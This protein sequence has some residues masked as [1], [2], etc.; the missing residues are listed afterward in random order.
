MKKKGYFKG[1]CLF[2]FIKGESYP[3]YSPTNLKLSEDLFGEK[4]DINDE[5]VKFQFFV[6]VILGNT[7]CEIEESVVEEAIKVFNHDNLTFVEVK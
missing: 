2:I 1:D 3:V 6:K 5:K 7:Y 4:V